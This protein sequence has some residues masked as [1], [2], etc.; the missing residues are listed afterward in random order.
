MNF[1]VH[2]NLNIWNNINGRRK[3]M[4]KIYILALGF[5]L[6]SC[7]NSIN[8]LPTSETT[9]DSIVSNENSNNE[10][11]SNGNYEFLI[12]LGVMCKIK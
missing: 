11:F 8:N 9:Q 5:L 1:I 4:K 7:E 2:V 10:V 6:S 3:K 12:D